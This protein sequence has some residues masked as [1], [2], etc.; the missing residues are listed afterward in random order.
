M[1]KN[2]AVLMGGRS[3]ERE[4]SIKSGQRISNALR[5]LGYNVI[6]LDMDQ[7]II[8]NLIQSKIDVAYIALHGKD[9]EDGTVQGML[10]TL[11][12]PYTGPGVYPN[13]LSFDKI[14]SKQIFTKFDIPTPPFYFLNESS[15]RELGAS[16]LLPL[17]IDKLGLPL[18]VKPSAQGSAL[19]IKMVQKKEEFSDA[20]I[21]AL[22][23]SKKILIEKYI[24]GCELAVSIIGDKKPKILPSVE[25]VPQKDFFDFSSRFSV[26]ETEYFVPARLDKNQ[27]KSVEE[28]A[29]RVHQVL[30]CTK[31]SR[32]DIIFDKENNVPYVLELNT[33][34]GMTDT[35]LLPMAALEAGISFEQLVDKIV[36]MSL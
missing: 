16:K 9:G 31:L 33:S 10:E 32:V 27:I 2:I 28:T 5:K 8:D 36:K 26:D 11:E 13:M 4:V 20:I 21:S 1:K 24:E 6:K 12:I 23:Y 22:G 18:I 17:I 19:G 35:S 7:N 3:L 30:D 34:P 25:I 14:I 15:F 29:L